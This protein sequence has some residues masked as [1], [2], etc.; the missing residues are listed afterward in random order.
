MIHVISKFMRTTL[1]R[2]MSLINVSNSEGVS[3]LL[4][5]V[6]SGSKHITNAVL[7][8]GARSRIICQLSSSVNHLLPKSCLINIH[9]D[10]WKLAK[11]ISFQ[12]QKCWTYT[13]PGLN[14]T[15]HIFHRSHFINLQE[16]RNRTTTST[17]VRDSRKQLRDAKIILSTLSYSYSLN[18][19]M[20]KY[21]MGKDPLDSVEVCIIGK[22]LT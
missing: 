8:A 17:Q 20:R 7:G 11:L 15:S 22:V 2:F 6:K 19:K 12:F 16:I 3:P 4:M 18:F 1:F 13:L 5:A 10:N 14:F 21:F 9:V